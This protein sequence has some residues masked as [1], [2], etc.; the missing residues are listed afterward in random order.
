MF[1]REFLIVHE[2]GTVIFHKRFFQVNSEKDIVIRS[3]LISALF[4]FAKEVENDAIDVLQMEKVTLLFKKREALIFVLFLD[5]ELDPSWCRKDIEK[6]SELFYQR[7][8]EILWQIEIVNIAQFTPFERDADSFL[9]ILNKKLELIKFLFDEGLINEEEFINN[10][11]NNIGA[12]VGTRLL[13]INY[14]L[15]IHSRKLGDDH[16]YSQIDNLLI[17]LNG[18]H[19]ERELERTYHINC[20]ECF[21]CDKS[22]NQTNCFFEGLLET[23]ISALGLSI[24]IS[25]RDIT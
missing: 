19:I 5:S 16:I 24:E 17:N 10:D 18:E 2:Y 15:F 13:E 4:N 1:I 11:L 6:L 8:P 23:L 9:G 22:D 20:F 25:R 3:G 14:D 21:M 7:F 12:I